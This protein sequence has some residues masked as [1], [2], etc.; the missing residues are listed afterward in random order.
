V[1]KE[2]GRERGRDV[3]Q[4]RAFVFDT[5][6]VSVKRIFTMIGRQDRGKKGREEEKK[7]R[8]RT[9]REIERELQEK[10]GE[11]KG[12]GYYKITA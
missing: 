6:F 11:G 7:D 5:G 4:G 12:R 3:A 8:T 9:E 2:G 1:E 10:A